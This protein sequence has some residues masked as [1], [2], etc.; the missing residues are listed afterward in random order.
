MPAIAP[1]LAL[2]RQAQ[3]AGQARAACWHEITDALLAPQ[4]SI[5][6]KYFY[7]RRGSELFEAIKIGRAHV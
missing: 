7:D 5:S 1:S 6:P 3:P 2:P 4:A